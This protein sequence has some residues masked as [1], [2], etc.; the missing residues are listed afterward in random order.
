MNLYTWHGDGVFL[1]ATVIAIAESLPVAKKIIK[2]Q[3]TSMGLEFKPYVGDPLL[4]VKP[5]CGNEVV[6]YDNGDY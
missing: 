4:D 2:K 3:V 5:F 6:H 1:G